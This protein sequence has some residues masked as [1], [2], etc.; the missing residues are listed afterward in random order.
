MIFDYLGQNENQE[1]PEHNRCL[2]LLQF[3]TGWSV[4]PFGGVAKKLKFIFLPDDDKDRLP[5]SSA[6]TATL[7]LPTIYSSK[8]KFFQSMDIVLKYGKVGF[9]NP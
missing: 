6:C 8:V 2:S 4:I 9:P 5:T 3:L 1:F 7:R